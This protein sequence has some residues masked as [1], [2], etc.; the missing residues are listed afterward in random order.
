MSLQCS[1][2]W[3]VSCDVILMVA[4]CK[5]GLAMLPGSPLAARCYWSTALSLVALDESNAR[6][7][8]RK[9]DVLTEPCTN[10][11]CVCACVRVCVCVCVCVCLSVYVY[12]HRQVLCRCQTLS[13]LEAGDCFEPRC[14][15][16]RSVGQSAQFVFLP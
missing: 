15:P 16:V 1:V 3:S 14:G 2:A 12:R 6:A 5:A 7:L 4:G 13:W 9:N 11:T 10:A 8:G